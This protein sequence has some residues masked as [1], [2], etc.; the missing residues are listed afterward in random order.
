MCRGEKFRKAFFKIG[1][2]RSLV[3]KS[4]NVM[5]LTATATEQTVATVKR[6]LA[7]DDHPIMVGLNLDRSNIKYIVKPS[8]TLEEFTTTIAS[9]LISSRVN[10]P[11]TVIFCQSLIE[12]AEVFSMVK[13]KLGH[14][15]SEPPGFE[16]IVELRL[17]TSFTAVS[18]NE[19]RE[20]IIDE[21]SKMDSI[22]RVVIASSAFGMG[23][24]IPDISRVI[25][26][27]LPPTLEDLV[28]QTGRAGRNGI[29]A[30]AILYS[31]ISYNSTKPIKDYAANTGYCRRYLLFKF[32]LFSKDKQCITGCRCCD[33]CS[34]LCG[35]QQCNNL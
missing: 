31:N 10:T 7:M 30:D 25:N 6:Q 35:C 12:C 14:E 9:E 23:V 29:P 24:N 15:I 5:A 4:V 8:I 1:S 26:W 20:S 34:S 27:G 19:H 16:H 17:L 22:L 13:V 21:F 11:K 32:F 18:S 33:L 3:P 2:L 28:Q